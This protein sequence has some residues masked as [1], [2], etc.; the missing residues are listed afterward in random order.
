MGTVSDDIR[1]CES[2]Q[3]RDGVR[4][5]TEGAAA[6]MMAGTRRHGVAPTGPN[7][8]LKLLTKNV[9]ETTPTEELTEHL[10]HGKNW[11]S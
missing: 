7:G 6:A 5:G 2:T 1:R 11:P 10:G 4:A 8:L 9:L 3:E